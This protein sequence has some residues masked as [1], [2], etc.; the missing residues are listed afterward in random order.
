MAGARAAL[1]R[2]GVPDLDA[3]AERYA[4]AK[5]QQL[6]ELIEEG[7]FAAFL[8]A[9]RFILAVKHMGIRVPGPFAAEQ[10]LDYDFI[11]PAM[12]LAEMFGADISGRD[13]PKGKPDPAIF[14]TAAAELGV[15]PSACFVASP[16]GSA[17]CATTMYEDLLKRGFQVYEMSWEKPD[18]EAAR[19]EF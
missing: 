6:L 15:P 4:A 8:D 18:R 11:G 2:F 10:R 12:T 13:F 7:R 19:L 3:R 9:L 16:T 5:Q 17:T 1:G 14:L